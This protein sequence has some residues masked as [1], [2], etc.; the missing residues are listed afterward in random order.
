MNNLK[1]LIGILTLIILILLGLVYYY[2]NKCNENFENPTQDPLSQHINT[3]DETI[4]KLNVFSKNIPQAEQ[5]TTSEDLQNL[6]NLKNE[7]MTEIQELN[8]A[9]KKVL[10]NQSKASSQSTE[11]SSEVPQSSTLL[12]SADIRATQMMQDLH[13]QKLKDRLAK[14][15]NM[16]HAHREATSR[17]V[18]NKIPV[19]SSCII[20][21]ASGDYNVSSGTSQTSQTSQLP[22]STDPSQLSLFGMDLSS[23]SS[24]EAPLGGDVNNPIKNLALGDNLVLEDIMKGLSQLLENVSG[25][26]QNGEIN[27]NLS[28]PS[29]NSINST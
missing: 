21:E 4:K 12:E 13:I 19:Y 29:S 28:S 17:K 27:I 7:L 6:N 18:Y 24:R 9:F 1:L 25:S 15:K 22:S 14:L 5:T 16:Y 8:V 3:T 20:A 23:L 11:T 2:W 10:E 26:F